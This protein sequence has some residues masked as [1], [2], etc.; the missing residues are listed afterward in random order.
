MNKDI[1]KEF[2]IEDLQAEIK[3]RK[4]LAKAEERKSQDVGIAST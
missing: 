2:S 4:E 1:L 3:R